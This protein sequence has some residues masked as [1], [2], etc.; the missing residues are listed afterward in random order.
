[1]ARLVAEQRATLA[2]RE[3]SLVG[4]I[5]ALPDGPAPRREAAPD[6][7]GAGPGEDP[8]FGRL[9]L[10]LRLTQTRAALAWLDRVASDAASSTPR[11]AGTSTR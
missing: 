7:S 2:R 9:V 4:R 10:E 6:G 5:A 11:S 8:G 3:A 1:V